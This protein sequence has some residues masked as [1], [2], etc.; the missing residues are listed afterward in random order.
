MFFRASLLLSPT[1][2]FKVVESLY[3]YDTPLNNLSPLFFSSQNDYSYDQP[4]YPCTVLRFVSTYIQQTI[5]SMKTLENN[6]VL[7]AFTFQ[8]SANITSTCQINIPLG[9]SVDCLNQK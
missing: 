5:G 8:R 3:R 2:N 7:C 6:P 4:L 1:F 9:N